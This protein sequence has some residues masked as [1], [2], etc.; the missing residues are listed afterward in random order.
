LAIRNSFLNATSNF[1][2]KETDRQAIAMERTLTGAIL[3]RGVAYGL[4]RD[5]IP[6]T[7][8]FK[9]TL[10]CPQLGRDFLEKIE[11]F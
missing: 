1:L 4:N 5:L 8:Q 3:P 11:R 6:D 7:K 2:R 9:R 10:R